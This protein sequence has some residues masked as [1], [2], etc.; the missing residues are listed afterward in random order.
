[1]NMIE[2]TR[3]STKEQGKSGLGIA[4]QQAAIAHFAEANGINIISPCSDVMSGKGSDALERRPGLAKALALARQHKCAVL[5]AKLDRLS[6]D[7]HFISGLMAD[8][9]P[10]YCVDLG[11]SADPFQL[12]IYAA[13]AEKERLMISERTRAALQRKKA[14]G[15]KLGTQ[16]PA[17]LAAAGGAAMR[18]AADV[19]ALEI[20]GRVRRIQAA[21]PGA[22]LRALARAMNEDKIPSMRGA[23]W[24]GVTLANVIE[25]AEKF[26]P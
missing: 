13:L 9:T 2:Y 15:Q 11:L 21:L 12:H 1:M 17:I 24:S 23:P 5:V 6:R 14:N 8:K 26:S 7:M 3:V 16:Q 10:F 22:S 20:I 18:E 4:A 25:R 19:F